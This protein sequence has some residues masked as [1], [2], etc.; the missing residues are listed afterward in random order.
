MYGKGRNTREKEGWG[1]GREC[2]RLFRCVFLDDC[3]SVWV[4][5]EGVKK[6]EGEEGE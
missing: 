4:G 6:K 2:L 3:W 1:G 5:E